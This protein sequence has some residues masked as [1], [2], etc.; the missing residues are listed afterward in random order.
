M[1]LILSTKNICH[2]SKAFI[3]GCLSLLVVGGTS[4]KVNCTHQALVAHTYIP[5]YLGG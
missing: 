4:L 3:M 2:F 5:S 1:V